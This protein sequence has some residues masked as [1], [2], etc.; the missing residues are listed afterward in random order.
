MAALPTIF[1]PSTCVRKGLCPVTSIRQQEGPLESH[2][3]YFEQHGSGP[4]KIVLIMGLN[5]S[6]F[7]WSRQVLHFGRSP[8]YSVLIFD[9]RGVGNSG[10]PRG[11]YTTSG[12]AEDVIVLLDFVGWKEPRSLHVVGLSLGGMIAQELTTRIPER[13]A[14]LLLGVTTAGG[15][16][17]TNF[18]PWIGIR[19]LAKA[20][21]TK[22]IDERIPLL[23]E[24]VYPTIWLDAKV[25]GDPQGR[26]NRQIETELYRARIQATRPQTL[27]GALS[28][29]CAGLTHHVSPTRLST[30]SRVI[31]KVVILTG[32]E[33]QLVAT[34][35]SFYLKKH[36]KE[37]EFIQWKDT[38]HG[39]HF[40]RTK[41]FNGAVER[42][43]EESR[44][45]ATSE[46]NSNANGA[47]AASTT[48]VDR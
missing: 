21:F 20:T 13:I 35:N 30:I 15:Y 39:I 11:P 2:S 17:W 7:G 1:D 47:A 44:E 8:N 24:M 14:S 10:T 48:A 41:E 45:R 19:N 23:H 4:E 34:E 42:M 26:T 27:L 9:N 29:M 22:D 40:Q 5:S 12:M 38:G 36:M 32:D 46:Q 43:I 16:P 33:D 6:S 37:A 31:P 25:E 18:P 28:Q 3:L